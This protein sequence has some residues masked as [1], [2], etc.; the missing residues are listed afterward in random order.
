MLSITESEE[1]NPKRVKPSTDKMSS[2]L[3][4]DC[5]DIKDPAF[6]KFRTNSEKPAFEKP[7]KKMLLPKVT[8]SKT[9]K[10]KPKREHDKRDNTSSVLPMPCEGN[11]KPRCKESK[12]DGTESQRVTPCTNS[13][14]SRCKKSR[15]DEQKPI[16]TE[17]LTD[18][19][20]P[21]FTE[22]STSNIEPS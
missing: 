18:M 6:A 8:E 11:D 9:S 14:K 2:N 5:V 10:R 7:R 4:K 1:T 17:F 12:A 3:Q 19:V 20:L 15:T 22:S 13:M 16:L 21:K